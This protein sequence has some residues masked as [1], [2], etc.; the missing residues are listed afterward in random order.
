MSLCEVRVKTDDTLSLKD[1]T[2]PEVLES[3]GVQSPVVIFV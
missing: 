1:S 2:G 3:H